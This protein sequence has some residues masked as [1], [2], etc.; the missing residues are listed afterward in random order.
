VNPNCYLEAGGE[1][2]RAAKADGIDYDQLIVQI[3][4]LAGARY[5]R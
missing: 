1:F 4:E 5:S 2:A 3:V